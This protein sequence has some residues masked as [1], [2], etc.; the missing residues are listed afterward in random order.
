MSGHAVAIALPETGERTEFVAANIAVL[1][2]EKE[3]KILRQARVIHKLE[4][5]RAG[6][7]KQIRRMR[8]A[9]LELLYLHAER[10]II[11]GITML[12]S[13]NASLEK[14]FRALH[15]IEPV[16][17]DRIQSLVQKAVRRQQA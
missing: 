15:L 4:T 14:A 10:S 7:R 17:A 16:S 13:P 1:I 5:A 8:E 12:R 6:Q 11:N 2:T 3:G 9:M